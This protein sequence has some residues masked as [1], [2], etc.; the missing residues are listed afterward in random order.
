MLR[1]ERTNKLIKDSGGGGGG[2]SAAVGG[3]SGSDRELG[4]QRANK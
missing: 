1:T 3:D 4:M 2:G